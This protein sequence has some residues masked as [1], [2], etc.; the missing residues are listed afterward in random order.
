MYKTRCL[1]VMTGGLVSEV[2]STAGALRI[3]LAYV[4]VR[5]AP[6]HACVMMLGSLANVKTRC[7]K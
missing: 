1:K 5:N 7:L 2:Q 3:A 6:L 4:L